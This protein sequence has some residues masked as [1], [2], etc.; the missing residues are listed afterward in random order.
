MKINNIVPVI[1]MFYLLLKRLE[2]LFT[3][4]NS[5][6]N[7]DYKKNFDH[8][9]E[10]EFT[11]MLDTCC[12]KFTFYIREDGEFAVTSE[13]FRSDEDVIDVSSTVLHMLN[14][15]LLAEYFV[16]SL[17]LWGEEDDQDKKF[18]LEVIKRWKVLYEEDT[19]ADKKSNKKFKLA[20]DPSDVFGLRSLKG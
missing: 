1:P 18:I 12:S 15:G 7:L 20:V 3:K 14:S 19:S 8:A 4:N 11:E 17:K 5:T 2:Q 16:K 10:K 6:I 13:F 9:K